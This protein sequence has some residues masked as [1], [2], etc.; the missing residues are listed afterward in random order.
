[1]SDWKWTQIAKHDTLT[2]GPVWNG[3][4]LLYNECA[5]H[6]T[7]RWD[8]KREKVLYGGRIQVE[9][10]G[11]HSIDRDNYMFARGMRTG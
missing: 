5:A 6:R 8:P 4:G 10:T 7:F 1:M 2:E 9:P 3:S 11:K